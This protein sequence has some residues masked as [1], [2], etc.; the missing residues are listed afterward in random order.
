MP[1]PWAAKADENTPMVQWLKTH[2]SPHGER[3]L[4]SLKE[5]KAVVLTCIPSGTA[6]EKKIRA[7]L[8]EC[9]DYCE[10]LA[11]VIPVDPKEK[12]QAELLRYLKVDALQ[13][14]FFASIA[15]SGEVKE[16]LA[17]TL[18]RKKVIDLFAGVTGSC[19]VE[20]ENGCG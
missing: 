18:T 9:S 10:R 4:A 1:V 16:R 11:N 14:P 5:D 3:I 15:L 19:G 12:S 17:G 8:T 7:W 2:P 20:C 13:P 6:N